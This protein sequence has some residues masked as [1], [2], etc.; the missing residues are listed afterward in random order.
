MNLLRKIWFYSIWI[1]PVLINPFGSNPFALMRV[2]FLVLWLFLG[3]CFLVKDFVFDK[4]PISIS[5][6]YLCFLIVSV[7]L[8]FIN[9]FVSVTPGET[10]YGSED[11]LQ[12]VWTFLMY[13]YFFFLMIQNVDFV[14]DDF[15]KFGFGF[16]IIVSVHA[17]LQKFGWL[18]FS[19]VMYNT[20]SQRVYGLVGHPNFLGQLLGPMLFVGGYLFDKE[21]VKKYKL[22]ILMGIL[23]IGLALFFTLNRATWL[24]VVL[25]VGVLILYKLNIS[26][27]WKVVVVCLGVLSFMSLV[28]FVSPSTR[29]LSTRF[30]LWSTSYELIFDNLFFGSGLESFKSIYQHLASPSLML[31]EPIYSVASRSHNFILDIMIELGLVGLALFISY[32]VSIFR[33]FDENFYIFVGFLVVLVSLQFSF[34]LLDHWILMLV[35]SAFIL[36]GSFKK[37]DSSKDSL[38]VSFVVGLLLVI[39]LFNLIFVKNLLISDVKYNLGTILINEEEYIVDGFDLIF[40][41]YEAN[42]KSYIYNIKVLNLFF[43]SDAII[44]IAEYDS[45]IQ[46][47]FMNMKRLRGEDFFY[48]FMRGQ[49]ATILKDYDMA[50][51]SYDLALESAPNN[52]KIIREIAVMNFYKGNCTEGIKYFENYIDIIP[53]IWSSSLDLDLNDLQANQLRIFLKNAGG[54]EFWRLF[55]L[56]DGCYETPLYEDYYKKKLSN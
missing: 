56:A 49:Y 43:A 2:S 48:H 55:E 29:S 14:D 30:I 5:K 12:G 24:A 10:L 21:K 41:A 23:L 3:T 11:R 36:K 25:G 13:L 9:Y 40:E 45:F 35:F 6:G 15:W 19:D 34:P 1:L 51:K 47:I 8:L 38:F 44:D 52:P 50:K 7:V 31:Y 26:K 22:L 27:F 16:Y 37:V 20:Y 28:Y 42:P 33:K 46:S 4:K 53:D 17:I 39:N 18:R 32:V 54:I